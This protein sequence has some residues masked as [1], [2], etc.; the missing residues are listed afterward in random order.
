MAKANALTK[1]ESMVAALKQILQL[2]RQPAL[3]IWVL[4]IV[5]SPFY[6]VHGGLPQPGDALIFLLVPVAL[7]RWSGRLE[8]TSVHAMQ[9]LLWFTYWVC[10]VNLGWAIYIARFSIDLIYSFYYIYNTALFLAVL[11]MYQRWKNAFLKLTVQIVFFTVLFQVAASFVIRGG[12]RNALFF[13]NPNQLG[14]Y[15]LLSGCILVLTQRQ[16]GAGLVRSSI[17]LTGCAYLAV[18]SASRSALSGIALL[19]VLLFFSNPR[20]F[21]TAAIVAIMLTFAG[22]PLSN[23]VDALS[24]RFSENRAPD[25]SFFEQRGYDRIWS[26]KEYLLT[27]AGEGNTARFAETTA[28]GLGEIH[29]SAG[30]VLFSYGMVG[31]ALFLAFIWRVLRGAPLRSSLILLP[32]LIYGFAHQGLR[33]TMLWVLLA[34][35]VALKGPAKALASKKSS[36]P[37]ELRP[38]VSV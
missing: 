28:I 22:G 25:K 20:V 37:P 1:P 13:S 16:L 9:P 29:S 10:L 23:S 18:L 19:A 2:C 24:R 38:I 6:V 34:I 31:V 35:F 7:I 8:R 33:F 12:T 30:T 4:Y 17:G 27:G 32:P 11:V 36:T 14:Y 5:L 3:A 26:N 21:I 15:A